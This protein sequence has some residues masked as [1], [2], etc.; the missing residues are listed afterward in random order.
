MN[1]VVKS[2][3]RI[4][5]GMPNFPRWNGPGGKYFLPVT[6][7]AAKGIAYDVDVRMMNEPAKLRKATGLPSGIAPRPVAMAA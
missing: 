3:A 4:L 1:S 7:F 6:I 5:T 2:T